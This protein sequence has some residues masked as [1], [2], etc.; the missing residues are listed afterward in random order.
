MHP[1]TRRHLVRRIQ[2]TAISS[3]G[4]GVVVVLVTACVLLGAKTAFAMFQHRLIRTQATLN[5]RNWKQSQS[6]A[7]REDRQR[8][9]VL[10][11]RDLQNTNQRRLVN[12]PAEKCGSCFRRPS[13]TYLAPSQNFNKVSLQVTSRTEIWRHVMGT[14]SSYSTFRSF[15]LNKPWCPLQPK[16]TS[17]W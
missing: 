2:K 4:D 12:C 8:D 3:I 9:Q 11:R 5:P 15:S 13:T 16:G 7:V 14:C 6:T 10:S 1:E 17:R